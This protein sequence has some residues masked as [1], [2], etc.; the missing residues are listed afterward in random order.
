MND[1]TLLLDENIEPQ[2]RHRLEHY[3]HPVEHVLSHQTLR[4]SDPDW[5]LAQYSVE[6]EALLVTYDGDFKSEIHSSE[7]WGAL[8]I[9]DDDWSATEVAD[10][11]HSI[12]T[13]YDE[14][15]LKRLNLVGREWL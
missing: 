5:K 2:V 12:L 3:G 13:H 6:N 8:L 9:S 15:S 10:T 7:Y 11:V 14:D 1:I 4:A